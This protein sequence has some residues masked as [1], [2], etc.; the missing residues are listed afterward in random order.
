MA[1]RLVGGKQL[2]CH[3]TF[4]PPGTRTEHK[5]AWPRVAGADG[6]CDNAHL[7]LGVSAMRPLRP[8]TAFALLFAA[9]AALVPASNAMAAGLELKRVM[10]SSGGVGYFEYAADVD[11]PVSLGLDVP[12]DQVDDVLKSLV[13]FDSAGGVGGLELPGRDSS[14]AA[15]GDVPFGP[16]ALNSPLDFLNSLQGVEVTVQGPRPITGRI[17]QA[18]RVQE[19]AGTSRDGSPRTVDRTRVSVLTSDGLRQFVLED[20]DAVQIADPDLRDR[21][22]KALAALRHESGQ[23]ARHITIRSAGAGH[24]T[25]RVGYVAVAPLWKASYRLVLPPVGADPANAKARLQG[26]AT[27]EN[28][29]GTDWNGVD[30]ALQYGNPVTFHQA[31]YRSYFVQRPEVP[32]EVLGRLLP[33]VDTRARTEAEAESAPAPVLSPAAGASRSMRM[34]A[35]SMPAPAPPPVAMAAPIQEVA[36]VEGGE[37]TVFPLP[38]PVTLSAGHSASVPIIDK[39]VPGERIALAQNGQ[40]HPLAAV[41]IT[42]TTGVSFPAGVLTLYDA[43]GAAPYAGDARLGGLPAGESRLLSF[44]QDLRTALEWRRSSALTLASLTAASGVLRIE[45]RERQTTRVVLTGPATEPRHVLVEIPKSSDQTVGDDGAKPSEET[46]TAW[47]FSVNL[48]PGEVQTLTVNL[49][50]MRRQA[51]AIMNDTATITRVL[52]EQGVSDAARAAL[53][54]IGELRTAEGARASERDALHAQLAAVER[55]EERL[56]NNL[57][58][59]PSGDALHSRLVR[60]LDADETRIGQLNQFIDAADQAVQRA[61]QALADAV[62][63]LKI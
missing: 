53:N 12:L 20:S 34:S 5:R 28:A 13:V 24:R 43:G 38:T 26:W 45:E 11:G 56:R 61:H 23:D 54:R 46:A 42:N 27:L 1:S 2:S 30:L 22:A 60:Q 62:S 35:A 36:A 40:P 33:D 52:N 55:D 10:L 14:H 31:I 8:L 9:P 44:A 51:T 63:S 49:D 7:V 48:K 21:V 15:F 29:S 25:I 4:A 32:V 57:N 59:V 16:E 37:E 41:K 18:E 6:A 47:R 58:A 19:S 17:L 3:A 50:R 39:E